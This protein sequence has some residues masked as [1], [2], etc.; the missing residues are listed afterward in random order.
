M[1]GSVSTYFIC[2]A[3]CYKLFVKPGCQIIVKPWPNDANIYPN[4]CQPCWVFVGHC[5]PL[6]DVGWPNEPN[7]STQH[8]SAYHSNSNNDNNIGSTSLPLD[9]EY[10]SPPSAYLFKKISNPCSYLG[11]CV[12]NF[13]G[14]TCENLVLLLSFPNN[15]AKF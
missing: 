1:N 6:L 8:L 10:T 9:P 3:M 4:K 7:I 5:W 12:L 14:E 2:I 11:P 13:L 15:V